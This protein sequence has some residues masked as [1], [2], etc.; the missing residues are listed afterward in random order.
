[1]STR[2]EPG[3]RQAPSPFA[4]RGELA[5][6]TV[7]ERAR[8]FDRGRATDADVEAAVR[9]IIADVRTRGDAALRELALRFDRVH[10]HSLEVSRD[11]CASA[12]RDLDPQVRAA[13]EQAAA[14]IESFHRAQLPAPLELETE[15]G[16]VLGRRAEPLRRV[17]VYAP[18]G[19]AA[20]ASSVLMGVVPARVAG[21]AEVVV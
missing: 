2:I 10:L 21:V 13:L 12:L 15:P 18:G 8:L 19:G 6:L 5:K 3:L 14:N 9:A 17:G 1:M 20:Y 7:S 4:V 16:I 11:A